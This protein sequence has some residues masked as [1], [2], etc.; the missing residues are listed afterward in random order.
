VRELRFSYEKGASGSQAV[1][2]N[3]SF[4]VES[5]EMLGIVGP[6]G[7][8]K[9]S[10]LKLLANIVP[11]QQGSITLFGKP[12]SGLQQENVAKSVAF[13]P[14]DTHQMFPFS[15]AETVLTGRFPHHHR[16]FWDLG[17][18]WE[19]LDDRVVAQQAMVTMD[20]WHLAER[21]VT[22]LSGGERQRVIIAR[23]LAQ[24]PEVLLLDEPTAGLD[25]QSRR[26]VREQIRSLKADG[27]TVLLTTHD[28]D[29]AE[30]LCD[31][32]A[33]I[34]RGE[35]LAVGEP[36]ALVAEPAALHVV[37]ALT[38]AAVGAERVA[39]IDAAREISCRGNRIEFQTADATRSIASLTALLQRDGIA[40]VELHVQRPSL[41]DV[42]LRLTR[43]DAGGES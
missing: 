10:L 37:N 6:N 41:E 26:D 38:N 27:R 2:Q 1:I 18:G 35:I 42:F 22:G 17:F 13:V 16:T 43:G 33:I 8:G 20:V 34:D 32:V 23:A 5:G 39:T 12:L 3:V 29:E 15:V 7:S 4:R 24:A 14:Q 36:Q 19:S 40:I 21:P 28:I 30:R 31:R 9:T 25:P 11:Q